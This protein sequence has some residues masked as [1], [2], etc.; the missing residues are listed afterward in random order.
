MEA[1]IVQPVSLLLLQQSCPKRASTNQ[2]QTPILA[3]FTCIKR[4]GE[5]ELRLL[6]EK[7][8]AEERRIEEE[9]EELRKKNGSSPKLI[10]KKKRRTLSLHLA[11]MRPLIHWL[12]SLPIPSPPL[13]GYLHEEDTE[14][15]K[16]QNNNVTFV[17]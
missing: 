5:E 11:A 1:Q 4:K 13:L 15:H 16:E 14:E 2:L 7:Q 17:C 10:E 6:K 9:E 8:L 12:S 3:S